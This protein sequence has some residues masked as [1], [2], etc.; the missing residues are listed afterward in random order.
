MAS[1][2]ESFRRAEPVTSEAMHPERRE[3]AGY[4]VALGYLRGFLVVLVLAHHSVI[5]YIDLSL[6]QATSLLSRPQYWRAFMVIDREHWAGFGIFTGF[7]D[8]FFM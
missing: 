7:N 6:P 5:A 3:R 4:N 8:T 1:P 2:L